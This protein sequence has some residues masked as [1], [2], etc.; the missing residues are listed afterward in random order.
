MK[1][2]E[3]S[4]EPPATSDVLEKPTSIS[5]GTE[6]EEDEG[7]LTPRRSP[8]EQ[9][10]FR[11]RAASA[12]QQARAH[13]SQIVARFRNRSNT[14]EDKDKRRVRAGGPRVRR[15]SSDGDIFIFNF[16]RKIST[17]LTKTARKVSI[18]MV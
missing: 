16:S 18:G 3:E 4:R 12:G 1:T 17:F 15:S 11:A 8:P 9:G 2:E 6:V 5:T 10:E 14:Q 13:V 7:S